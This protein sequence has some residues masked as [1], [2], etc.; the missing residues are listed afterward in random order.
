[1]KM[2]AKRV[3]KNDK[4]KGRITIYKSKNADKFAINPNLFLVGYFMASLHDVA[5]LSGVSKST[6]SRVINN[7]W[8]FLNKRENTSCW[9]ILIRFMKKNL[10]IFRY[11][12]RNVSKESF[13]TQRI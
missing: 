13:S 1:V 11:L 2:I 3:G 10:N 5:R 4:N 9:P 7:E 12:T 6:V 8:P